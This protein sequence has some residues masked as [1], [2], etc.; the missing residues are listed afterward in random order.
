MLEKLWKMVNT[1]TTLEDVF[2]T[3]KAIR[4]AGDNITYDEFDELMMAL[5]YISRECYHRK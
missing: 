5:M 4:E 1:S 3:E 2:E